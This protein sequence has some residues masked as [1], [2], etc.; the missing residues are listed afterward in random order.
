M[1]RSTP[2][3]SCHIA[4]RVDKQ[5]A[6]PSVYDQT[7]FE[8]LAAG[9]KSP[10]NNGQEATHTR[11]LPYNGPPVI[12]TNNVPETKNTKQKWSQNEYREVIESYYTV[13]FFSSRK[14]N[15]IESYEIWREK[16]PTARLNMD[17]NKFATMQRTIIIKT[18]IFLRWTLM[19]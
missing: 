6:C 9:S 11:T 1:R 4:R 15:T 18:N 2:N 17:H 7:G 5:G 3:K 10:V 19:K 13:T 12:S 14:T 8:K 16:N